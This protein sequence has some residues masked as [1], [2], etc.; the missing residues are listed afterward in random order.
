MSLSILDEMEKAEGAMERAIE[1]L[2]SLEYPPNAVERLTRA[3]LAEY[4]EG[5]RSG[6]KRSRG[7]CLDDFEARESAALEKC[8][9]GLRA[10]G[11]EMSDAER[12]LQ[13][14]YR[15]GV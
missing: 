11:W 1:E 15:N 3:V 6:L 5:K 10:C 9:A 12:I 8:A 13:R 14:V 7:N 4:L 2:L